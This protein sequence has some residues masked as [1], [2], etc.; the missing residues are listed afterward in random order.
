MKIQIG[1]PHARIASTGALPVARFWVFYRG[2]PKSAAHEQPDRAESASEKE[3]DGRYRARHDCVQLQQASL[4][5]RFDLLVDH[6]AGESIDRHV[7]PVTL[8]AHND[9]I[10]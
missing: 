6:K 5:Y 10:S 1:A 9:K 8:L 7:H 2:T 4:V 3:K